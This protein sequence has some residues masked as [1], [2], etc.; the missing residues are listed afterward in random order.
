MNMQ[1]QHL[2]TFLTQG[3]YT[4]CKAFDTE[5]KVNQCGYVTFC[6]LVFVG[7]V[8]LS[9]KLPQSYVCLHWHRCTAHLLFPILTCS[10]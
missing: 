3:W 10:T 5:S 7:V 6:Q 4:V 1:S 8:S 2:F 9:L